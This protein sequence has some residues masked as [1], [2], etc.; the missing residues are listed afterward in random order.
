MQQ[1]SRVALVRDFLVDVRGAERVFLTLYDPLP[2]GGPAHGGLRRGGDRGPLRDRAGAH[3]LPQRLRP[4]PHPLRPAAAVRGGKESGTCGYD[5]VMLE[6]E[7]VGRSIIPERT[8][9]CVSLPRP[10]SAIRR[11]RARSAARAARW[12]R[13]ARGGVPALAS[14]GSWMRG[15]ARR[16]LRGDCADDPKRRVR[17]LAE[18]LLHPARDVRA[19]RRPRRAT[20]TSCSLRASW[21]TSS[22]DG[23]LR[24]STSCACRCSSSATARARRLHRMSSDIAHR[25]RRAPGGGARPLGARPGADHAPHGGVRRQPPSRP[26]PRRAGAGITGRPARP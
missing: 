10:V 15:P 3:L 1:G 20:P 6:L 17:P 19:P 22:K 11:T 2:A 13:G 12:R 25:P 14:M 7:R 9:L 21:P 26:R 18:G 24:R 23:R 4:A 16:R 8:Q 5:L